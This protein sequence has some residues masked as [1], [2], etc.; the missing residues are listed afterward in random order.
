MLK[1]IYAE[2]ALEESKPGV[3]THMNYPKQRPGS[4]LGL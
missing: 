4:N 3:E 1:G 2:T